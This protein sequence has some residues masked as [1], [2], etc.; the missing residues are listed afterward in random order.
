[1]GLQ[2]TPQRPKYDEWEPR[3]GEVSLVQ[4]EFVKTPSTVF[5]RRK[6]AA[7]LT[8][9]AAL[10]EAEDKALCTWKVRY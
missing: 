6:S 10:A 5:P 2:R 7:T 4:A 1:M 3:P 9:D 8:L